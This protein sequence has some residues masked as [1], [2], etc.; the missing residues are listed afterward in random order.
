LS[1]FTCDN[2]DEFIFD[3]FPDSKNSYF[4]DV[5]A[6]DGVYGSNT[7]SLEKRGWTGLCIEG[8]PDLIND[9]RENRSC[10]ISGDLVG[11]KKQN[12]EFCAQKN[13]S[14]IKGYFGEN[15]HGGFSHAWRGGSGILGNWSEEKKIES[16]KNSE[17]IQM[18][19]TTLTEILD[20]HSC[21]K[22][23][24]LLDIDTEGNDHNVLEGLDWDKYRF[25][26]ILIEGN[27]KKTKEKLD[28]LG[29]VMAQEFSEE[30]LYIDS[31]KEGFVENAKNIQNIG[32]W[33][34]RVFGE[35][36]MR[37]ASL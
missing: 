36:C 1:I 19:T 35:T 5:G 18:Q 7:F 15:R 37:R 16:K 31:K 14:H 4:V 12:V 3:L 20:R 22:Y 26:S 13:E 23:M 32:Y 9:L 28:S 29:Y 6:S 27:E 34:Q 33:S 24:E 2:K 25:A 11:D 17:I 30:Y 10:L 21:P 8:H